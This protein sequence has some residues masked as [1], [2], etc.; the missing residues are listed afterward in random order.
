MLVLSR[1]VNERIIIGGNIE[2]HV[3][4]IRGGKVRLGISAPDDVAVHRHEVHAKLHADQA[5]TA[6]E[7]TKPT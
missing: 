5:R 2:V 6:A 7:P 3:V 1:K 4:D